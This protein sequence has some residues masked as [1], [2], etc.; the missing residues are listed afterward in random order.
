MKKENG[1]WTFYV[2]PDGKECEAGQY[3][4]EAAAKEARFKA[5]LRWGSSG[6]KYGSLE[7]KAL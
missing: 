5:L 6:E 7:S 4:T 1:K 2:F 3:E